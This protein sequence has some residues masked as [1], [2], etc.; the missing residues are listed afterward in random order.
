MVEKMKK[1]L[2]ISILCLF[3]LGISNLLKAAEVNVEDRLGTKVLKCGK[4]EIC[5][6]PNGSLGPGLCGTATIFEQIS[7][8][9]STVR[10]KSLGSTANPLSI[11]P[12]QIEK[13][14][15][16]VLVISKGVIG[17][18]EGPGKW[19]Y[20]RALFLDNSGKMHLEYQIEKI[21]APE[22]KVR[23][24]YHTIKLP[25]AY[26]NSIITVNAKKKYNGETKKW[27]ELTV[28]YKGKFKGSP[29]FSSCKEYSFTKEPLKTWRVQPEA[30]FTSASF[31]S[32]GYI[33]TME[34]SI[35]Y[36]YERAPKILNASLIYDFSELIG[37]QK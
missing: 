28:P 4:V 26:D 23:Y 36:N 30:Y 5:I 32:Y 31:H 18:K 22:P 24:L 10:W 8:H 11:E 13:K 16:G 33:S 1:I 29:I 2:M 12:L 3:L 14:A 7:L 19:K 20:T 21:S 37:G 9:F 35:V 15:N 25:T 27:E 34:S 6:L 17:Q